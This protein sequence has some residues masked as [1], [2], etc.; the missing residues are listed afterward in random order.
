MVPG[1]F[2]FDPDQSTIRDFCSGGID[3]RR[4]LWSSILEF[5]LRWS[6]FNRRSRFRITIFDGWTR[7]NNSKP[8]LERVVLAVLIHAVEECGWRE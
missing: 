7:W 5:W 2:C 4:M 6:H 1:P 8:R 3:C